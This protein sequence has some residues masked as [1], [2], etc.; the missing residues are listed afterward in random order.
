MYHSIQLTGRCRMTVALVAALAAFAAPA[1]SAGHQDLMSPNTVQQ[2][3]HPNDQAGAL[4]V[5]AVKG[6]APDAFERYL[7]NNRPAPVVQS[8]GPDA[9]ERYLG[10]NAPVSSA[11]SRSARDEGFQW[12]DAGL[13]AGGMI[14]IL[15]LAGVAALL[16]RQG[17]ERLTSI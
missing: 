13:G 1:A 16:I 10:N 14:G 8:E 9:F 7:R 4:G 15:L 12:D 11:V 5:G 2:A 17:R 3:S 6:P